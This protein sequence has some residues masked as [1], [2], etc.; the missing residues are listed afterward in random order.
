MISQY[1]ADVDK[2]WGKSDETWGRVWDVLK[3]YL[4]QTSQVSR[5]RGNENKQLICMAS[6]FWDHTETSHFLLENVFEAI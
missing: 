1:D 3:Y 6:T 5:N 2:L 4:T